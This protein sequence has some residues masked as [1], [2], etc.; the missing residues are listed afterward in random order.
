MGEADRRGEPSL[1]LAEAGDPG[2]AVKGRP[3]GDAGSLCLSSAQSYRCRGVDLG[4]DIL[5]A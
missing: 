5:T 4:H 1:V 2:A 3:V